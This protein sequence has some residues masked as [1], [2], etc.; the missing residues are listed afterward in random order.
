M[1]HKILGRL[2]AARSFVF[3]ALALAG[4]TSFATDYIDATGN[5]ASA[6]CT[7]I[8]SSTTTLETGWYVVE[9][10]DPVSI[11]S[12]ITVNG[13]ANLILADGAKLTVSVSESY[14]AGILVANDGTTV[15]TLTIW[16][17]SGGTGELVVSGGFFAAGIGGDYATT[18]CGAVTI[19]GGSI[20]AT[21]N[22]GA[23][24]G[25]GTGGAGGD[26]AINGGTVVA[27]D[28]SSGDA[29]G[30]G[31]GA[32]SSKSQ[33]TLT[34]SDKIEVLAGSSESTAS[35]LTRNSDT[36]AVTISGQK[37]FFAGPQSL[38]QGATSF[39]AYSGA[40]G[41]AV[42]IDLTDTIKGGTGVYT[43]GLKDG[44]SLP[45][46]LTLSGT[47]LSGTPV[48][49][50]SSTFTFVVE[51]TS[52]P[53]L[54]LEATY[55]VVVKDRYS[56]TY[57]DGE[58]TL[59]LYP[60]NY[61]KGTG[62][63]TLP[64]P[65]KASHEF[66]G[67]FTN[68]LFA[69]TQFTSISTTDSG[70]F[71]FYSK[72]LQL[73]TGDVSVTFVG[74]GSAPITKTCTIVESSMT[75]L[76]DTGSTEGWYVVYNNVAFNSSVT[77]SGNVKLVL[78]DGKTMTAEIPNGSSISKAAITVTPGNS[79]T[80]YGQANGSGRIEATATSISAGI[81]G[82]WSQDCGSV[83]INGGTVIAKSTSG[84]PG[85]GGGYQKAGGTV[86]I[87]GGTVIAT[88]ASS[89]YPGIGGGGSSYEQ[90]KL[91]VGANVVVKAGSSSTL[92][93]A[94]IQPH[95]DGQIDLTTCYQYYSAETVGPAPLV[96][97]NSAFSAYIGE[98]FELSLPGTV[99]GG[100][101]PYS[102]TLKTPASLPSWLSRTG[103]TLSGTPAAV[104]D[105]C[106]LT[107]T[108]A[109]SGSPAQNA[110]F[111]YT[112]TVTALPKPITYMNGTV[113]IT[114]L[115]P[116]N[117]V[118][119]VG[120]TLPT[121]APAASGY[122]LEGW[123]LTPACD[124]EKV[125][126]I[127]AEATGPQTFYANWAPIEYTITYKD[128]ET[129]TDLPA[130]ALP[131]N[132]PTTYT[133]EAATMLPATAT[134]A[135][136]GFYGWYLTSA[137]TGDPETSI[138]AG[139]T[140]P[141]TF[142]AKWGI[143]K[144]NETYIDASGHEQ[145]VECTEIG[146]DT[147]SL[148]TGW[149]VV[150]GNVS[151]YSKVTVSGN[152]NLI[153][154]D[155]AVYTVSVSSYGE[156][157]MIK[158]DNS[159]TIYGGVAGTGALNV[160]AS[161][162]P[163]I[164]ANNDTSSHFGTLTVY[165]GNVTANGSYCGI[166]GGYNTP[167]GD[168]Y[169][170]G[171]TVIA[172]GGGSSAAGIGGYG[173]S[174]TTGTLTVAENV[175]VMTKTSDYGASYVMKPHGE[176]GAI[177]LE[178][179]QYYKLITP[180]TAT[181]PYR[182][183]DG[184]VKNATCTLVTADINS[185]DGG[186]Y[187]VTGNLDFGSSGIFISGDVKLIISDGASLTV[188]GRSGSPYSAGIDV[189]AGASL[190]VYG[191]AEG[192]GAITA[193]GGSFSAGIGG[194]YQQSAGTITI[195]GGNIT[196]IGNTQWS[197]GAGIGGGGNKGNGG[198]VVINGG[199]VEA[200]G[201][202][203]SGIGKGSNGT[204]EGTLSVGASMVVMAGTNA[205]SAV[206]LPR[207]EITGTV[208]LSSDKVRT[209]FLVERTGPKPLSQVSSTF[210][211]Y[212]DEAVNL[213]FAD[214]VS[215]GT[216]PY[217]FEYKSGSLPAGISSATFSGTPTEAGTFVFVVTVTDSGVDTEAQSEDF[218]Y[219][220]TVTA[221]PKTI[222]YYN[223][224]DEITGLTPSNY[225]EGV[226]ATLPTTAPAA[227]GYELEGWYT[228]SEC[229]PGDK[230]TTIS[231][232][233]TG[234]Q[235]FYANWKATVYNVVYMKDSTT[236]F[237]DPAPT[238]YTVESET[239]VLPT[240]AVNAG[241][242][243][244]G[245]YENSG[246]LGTPTT[247]IPHGSTGDKV[248]YAKWGAVKSNETYVNAAGAVQP[249]VEC[250]EIASDTTTLE[251]GWYIVK[252]DVR[253][254]TFVT[255]SGDASIILADGATLTITS[256]NSYKAGINVLNG[257]SLTVY[258]QTAA[259]TGAIDATGGALAAGI[260]GEWNGSAGTVTIN[261]GSVTATGGN[262]CAG[263]G[264]GSKGNGGV[265][266]VNNGTVTA[267]GGDF[268]A[269]IG[270][271]YE[272]SGGTVTINGGTVTAYSSGYGAGIGKGYTGSSNG[273]L[274][275]GANMVVES[276][277]DVGSLT[278]L[279]TG[280]AITLDGL[281]YYVVRKAGVAPLAQTAS[282]FAAYVGEAFE[283]NLDDTVRGGS[284]SYLFTLKDSTLPAWLTR[285]GN[286]LSGTPTAEGVSS[287]A[288]TVEDSVE[289]TVADLDC[290]YTITASIRPQPITYMDGSEVMTGLT[291]SNY[292]EG[293]GVELPET[294][295]KT[296]YLHLGWYTAAIGGDRVY[297]ISSEATG[298]QT[299]YA[300]WTATLYTIT[301][302]DGSTTLT[303]LEPTYYDIETATFNLP[304]PLAPDGK[305]FVGWFA[306]STFD[307][308]VTS[309]PQGSTG[310]KTVYVK[311]RDAEAGEGE[312]VVTFIDANGS[313]RTENC[314]VLTSAM[315]T[316]ETG[317]YVVNN[318]LA[319]NSS[320]TIDG[321]V[322]IV[323]VDGK[324]LT[325]NA[326][327]AWATAGIAVAA[328]SSLSIYGQ[329]EGTGS[330]NATG[331]DY[332]A[333]IGSGYNKN[334]GNVT[335]NGGT[336]TA[337][338]HDAAGIGGAQSGVCGTV[339]VNRGT[340][341]ATGGGMCPGIGS[342]SSASA[343]GIV[344][345]N[346]GDVTA[347]GGSGGAAGIGG[348]N[349]CPGGIVTITGGTVV[350]T[351][352]N[353][354]GIGGSGSGAG[355]AVTITG[356]SVSAIAGA[357]Y[358]YGIGGGNT[359]TDQG[360]LTVGD[361][362]VVRAGEGENPA[363]ELDVDS[364]GVVTLVAKRYYVVDDGS[365]P[366][367]PTLYEIQYFDGQ[368]NQ[369]Q[370]EPSKYEAGTVTV[371]GTPAE[372][373]G[374]VF[375]GWYTLPNFNSEKVTQIGVDETG[376]KMFYAKWEKAS[377]RAV[378]NYLDVDGVEKSV[379]CTIISGEKDLLTN[380]WY[381]VTNSVTLTH[382]L[383]VTNDVRLV[384]ADNVTLT[385]SN[386][387]FGKAG[388]HVPSDSF[389]TIFGQSGDS[390]VLSVTG[391]SYAAGIGGDRDEASSGAVTVN[392]GVV[393]AQGGSKG[394]GI[395]GGGSGSGGAVTINGGTVTA[396]GGND[397]AGIGG[398]YTGSCGAVTINGGTVTAN[399]G[400]S[401]YDSGAG[402]GGGGY[403]GSGGVVVINGGTVTATSGGRYSD[404]IGSG[405]GE[406][407]R[408]TLKAGAGVNVWAGA[409]ADSAEEL[410]QKKDDGT[411][412]I[413]GTYNY[414]HA[415]TATAESEFNIYYYDSDGETPLD[416]SPAKYQSG[417]GRA[418]L[419]TPD[420]RT[421]YTFA[422]WWTSQWAHLAEP[423][424]G[425][426]PG[427][428]GNVTI[429]AK[430]T[431]NT[432][433]ITYV[434]DPMAIED[435]E[436]VS[437]T[438]GTGVAE[439]PVPESSNPY[440]KFDG[441]YEDSVK[442]TSISAT[443]VGDKTLTA[444][445]IEDTTK[446]TSVTFV[447]AEG[448]QTES[449]R[450]L[451]TDVTALETGWYVVNTD[452]E[453]EA[454]G[455]AVSGD[456]KL[457]L[458][459]GASLTATAASYSQKAGINVP[460]GSSLTIYA[461]S[462]GTGELTVAGDPENLG[463]A[464]GI[465][466]NAN[467]SCG[468]VTIYGGVVTASSNDGGAGIGGGYKGHGG[469]VVI[470]GGTVT[471]TSGGYGAGIGGGKGTIN[472]G[473][474]GGSVT[475]N[476]GT[477]VATAD[478]MAAGIG[479]GYYGDGGTVAINGGVV[480]ATGG[481]AESG[482]GK[483]AGAENQVVLTVGDGISVFVGDSENP[484][485]DMLETDEHGVVTMPSRP[486]QYYIVRAD[487]GEPAFEIVDGVLVGANIKGNA[488]IV[489]PDSVLEIGQ[490]VFEDETALRS[491]VIPN[492]VTNIG[493]S[494]FDGCSSLTNVTFGTGVKSIVSYAFSGCTALT[495]VEIPGNVKD[496]GEGAF[497]G[498]SSLVTLTLGEG[499]ETLGEYAFSG[500]T[501][502]THGADGLYFPD[503]ITTIGNWVLASC[504]GVT[505]V[506][507][508]GSLY[509]VGSP[510]DAV[511][512]WSIAV[513][514]R[515]D[516]P[517]F[518]FSASNE[519]QLVRVDPNGNTSITLPAEVKEVFW[520][521]F[522][523]CPAVTHVTV[524]GTVTNILTRAFANFGSLQAVTIQE[525]VETIE[526]QAFYG[527]S[528]LVEV[529][530]PDSVTSLGDSVFGGCASLGSATIG[531]GVTEILQF[532]FYP[533]TS[534][535]NVTLGAGVERI[536]Y[537]AFWNCAALK[538]VNLPA[539]LTLIEN[540]AFWGCS[541]LESVRIPEHATVQY[542]AFHS[543]TGLE[544]VYIGKGATLQN[545]VFVDCTGIKSGNVAAS[546]ATP[547]RR[548]LKMMSASA[549]GMPLLGASSNPDATTLG[550]Y[551][552]YGCSDLESV[553]LGS[554]VEDIGGGVFAGCPKL[555]TVTVEEGNDSYMA[556]DGM[557]LTKD[558]STLVCAFGSETSVSVTS[559]V[560]RVSS[561]AFAGYSTLRSVVLPS[562]V[563]TIGE[564]AFSNATAFATIT[565]PA[566]V[567]T[568]GNNAFCDTAL[569]TVYVATGDRA[570]VKGLV[571]GTGYTAAVAYVEPGD[572]GPK[573]S[574][575]GDT[576]ATVTG[577][578]ESGYTVVP[579]STT[580]T[581]EVEIPSGLDPEKVTV[582][583]PPT[584]SVKPNGAI[585]AVVKTV[586]ATPYDITEFLL[587]PA[588]DANGVINLGEATVKDEIIEEVLDPEE[589]A[590][591][592]LT[593][594]NPSITTAETRPGLTYTFYEG[595]TLQ[596]MTQKAVKV[597]DG[598]AWMPTITVKGGTSGFYSVSVTK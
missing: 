586:D 186:W 351:G 144:S 81:G 179:E 127:S 149:Y 137:C 462:E 430:W 305:V 500:C 154:A 427:S 260:G 441:W 194:G 34:V 80:I 50:G 570:R 501:S 79:L 267:K 21:G 2:S 202:N 404:G 120:A 151:T 537:N 306:E 406:G 498:C 548:K 473:G 418:E 117:Y 563:V 579:S 536:A 359:A 219:T 25:G 93:D 192:T 181:V 469:T 71:T 308:Q 164:G 243:F 494:A 162:G 269:G 514:Y 157:I 419:P 11:S 274:T 357:A 535:T 516:A 276:G 115:T 558:G 373:P 143:A 461:Q 126:A 301:Y 317:W 573:P 401:S 103:D 264:G 36:G 109:D 313:E 492:S 207:D 241:K 493:Y 486:K 209:Y 346:G 140:G 358:R 304:E 389:L 442:V 292:I 426:A 294:A 414:Y 47:T 182:D 196:A 503:S 167:G 588:A 231:A 416:L 327:N 211:V 479:G 254:T 485:I 544:S 392:G 456:V 178:G 297:S 280:G 247:S 235:V 64:T 475:I 107:F 19:Y 310:N 307:T 72:W 250:A 484:S 203:A 278:E 296:G 229:N 70:D 89:T 386:G 399:G 495:E 312:V 27:R 353:G 360:S 338:G 218:T 405:N 555:T 160:S 438:Y 542:F 214:T 467:E 102:F 577:D 333:G 171:G 584:A 118:E 372:K 298:P 277:D 131:A 550:D 233:A 552:F 53:K 458:A 488:D 400:A 319:I 163:A 598:N 464:A 212:K 299:F 106:E 490:R 4:F 531:N 148:A 429:Y 136:K 480:T 245:W 543:C 13:D 293:V 63:S 66:Q 332:G 135:G 578:A 569:A 41:S 96:Q 590:V 391:G 367:G 240:T 222:T 587:I 505:K 323:L 248:F 17:Q 290:T 87:N 5:P 415:E 402:I 68:A 9:G 97:I 238:T 86:T 420:A 596:N 347:T 342:G 413:F 443:A 439:L 270:G 165:G 487:S 158:G 208:E 477:V 472:N 257:N 368:Y 279:G 170:Y 433:T 197:G 451:T 448:S 481:P 88:G 322:N 446:M 349:N 169:V 532:M 361:G 540:S 302:K 184:V 180:K 575:P 330:L 31:R 67:W 504:P 253:I 14:K 491:V 59:S 440:L 39:T 370:V 204:S 512:G 345:I 534:L 594:E 263:I 60:T 397:A 315:T 380:G 85:I 425:I 6:T 285:T 335:I 334:A 206:E 388:I 159:L 561:G 1:I 437:Y 568:I 428:T 355:A 518:H 348:G 22:Y 394:A 75:T 352:T 320:V 38:H 49:E 554:T 26:V 187:A 74:E 381:A 226:G 511:F 259:G 258:S 510:L 185:F 450:V 12:T 146:S 193:T 556:V 174:K 150:K 200:T 101:D 423:V 521:S 465:G 354:A 337:T 116:S 288:F 303:G 377:E 45:E 295:S 266:V 571:E 489:I 176:N 395:G 251:T 142:Y 424:T 341:V 145:V 497:Y 108:V 539:S 195:N 37:W 343:G 471:A 383:G 261:G 549:K 525:G 445:W 508:P 408:G 61:I 213:S 329:A 546:E 483:G 362:M 454:Q 35:L 225:V 265:V 105:S 382:G 449:C 515:T 152:V 29:A 113:E 99:S 166:G 583:V 262:N 42:N 65:T 283:L 237:D 410:T 51:D 366:I 580:G 23:G 83:T 403:G 246:C 482:I 8:T 239:L 513:T 562:G 125:T 112:I 100:T 172:N 316:L 7:Q 364:N 328:G 252:D 91:Y 282:A 460:E 175:V 121:T 363:D 255:V 48:E 28:G 466:G 58:S 325:V 393:I 153:L 173:S 132:A 122:E 210:D 412:W 3:A 376:V 139:Q 502:L 411:F 156:A 95:V 183:T 371:L 114:G 92:T 217:T 336:V 98:A 384:I 547:L 90:G 595:T 94:N 447:G 517:V 16:C 585:V 227:S 198:T 177:T 281:R 422:G 387:T 533:C 73:T 82:G 232:E 62:V 223:G 340:V 133:I 374:Y 309:I 565:I 453:Y 459:D 507:L 287:F 506:S 30:I 582:E 236:Q 141:K 528:N 271:G 54:S 161:S 522:T 478:Y 519:G 128:S 191:Q 321:N 32:F 564:A 43:F 20:T 138:S 201:N 129:L 188:A 110:E 272:G 476:G 526:S 591:L 375:V 224:A 499:V 434:T 291:P 379:E 529:T 55:T 530:V 520:T 273:S 421:G 205:T 199:R 559:S 331:G 509:T 369:I 545:N 230:V 567:T 417:T 228:T 326:N 390:G 189:P 365:A 134:K 18:D 56:I 119:G 289:T 444:R 378:V 256:D 557:L 111:T 566:S 242:A 284:G 275:V 589:G 57:K 24:I 40:A 527:C 452:L 344:I 220:L 249:A 324:T 407:T 409:N 581:V 398:G 572:E 576:E 455:L 593:P 52:E 216:K 77:I 10:P 431:A 463:Y 457:V 234:D 474:H 78:M 496:I 215:G 574:I 244:Y 168:V 541:S 311:W 314:K 592:V 436:P 339:T 15:N 130:S 350:A 286:V 560:T 268:G 300:P 123:Y 46:W 551:A 84:G 597:G 147:T 553:A 385:V 356:G 124:G 155:D 104:G 435:L 523:N 318:D 44:S 470:N 69:G 432:Y 524:P 33:G 396:S 76:S 468:T 221:K 538:D 190:T